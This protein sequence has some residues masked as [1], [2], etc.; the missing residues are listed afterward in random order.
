MYDR[1]TSS[2]SKRQLV[3]DEHSSGRG[4]IAIP[5]GAS[6][7]GNREGIGTDEPLTYYTVFTFF[8]VVVSEITVAVV[9]VH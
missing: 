7:C 6:R 2:K 9:V 4:S 3:I 5:L 1:P 8:S